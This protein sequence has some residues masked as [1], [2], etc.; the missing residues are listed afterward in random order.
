MF[1][2]GTW[3]FNCFIGASYSYSYS[4]IEF[5]ETRAHYRFSASQNHF[6]G[7]IVASL[8]RFFPSLAGPG[9]HGLGAMVGQVQLVSR[10][11]VTAWLSG[12]SVRRTCMIVI[13]DAGN[14]L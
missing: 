14:R 1:K 4:E 7:C 10:I 9:S 11:V 6:R 8:V 5:I 13:Q 12:R 3:S 2:F